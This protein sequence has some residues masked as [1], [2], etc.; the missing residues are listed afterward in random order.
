MCMIDK[1]QQKRILDLIQ[2]TLEKFKDSG[3]DIMFLT[4]DHNRGVITG[5]YSGL[6]SLLLWNMVA[7]PQIS[8]IVETAVRAY[9]QLYDQI[10][11]M[12]DKDK[13]A[14]EIVDNYETDIDNI[15][16]NILGKDKKD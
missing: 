1:E 2:E 3:I 5:S 6:V 12:V 16:N 13:P 8:L 10:K 11:E 7:Y 4:S 9:P 14:H 15:V